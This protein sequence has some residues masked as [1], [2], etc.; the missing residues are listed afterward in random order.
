[1]NQTANIICL[2]Q[3]CAVG[4]LSPSLPILLSDES[5]IANGP[6]TKNEAGWIGS[7]I[8]VG[9]MTG[10]L[11]FGIV[12]NYIGSK[13]SMICCSFPMIVSLLL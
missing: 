11:I 7:F 9:A 13:R 5:P 4:W 12:A 1:M 2:G 6:L 10:T 3:G 8:P